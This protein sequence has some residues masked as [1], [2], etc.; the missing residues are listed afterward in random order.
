MK[1]TALQKRFEEAS[2]TGPIDMVARE[3]GISP[4]LFLKIKNEGYVPIQLRVT[5]SIA[6][7]FR[8]R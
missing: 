4:A 1:K 2:K 5:N 7:Y 8:H 6:R 3:M